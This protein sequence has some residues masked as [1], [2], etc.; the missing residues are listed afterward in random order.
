MRKN[1]HRQCLRCEMS[2]GPTS[3]CRCRCRGRLHG[4]ARTSDLIDLPLDD[5]HH[6]AARCASLWAG[7]HCGR[8]AVAAD[9]EQGCYV[10]LKHSSDT[11]KARVLR[12]RGR[13]LQ[14]PLLEET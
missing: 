2:D 4:A 9:P 1:S 8:P 12:A 11:V 3:Q 7:K 5:P 13:W 6:P 14:L 10:C